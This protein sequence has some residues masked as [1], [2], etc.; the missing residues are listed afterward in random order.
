V[1]HVW[2]VKHTYRKET[3][4]SLTDLCDWIGMASPQT[5]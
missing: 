3:I 4:V 2:N 5:P 1:D